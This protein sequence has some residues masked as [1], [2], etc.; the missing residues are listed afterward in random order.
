MAELVADPWGYSRTLSVL[1]SEGLTVSEFPWTPSRLVAAT[2]DVFT[3]RYLA[4]AAGFKFSLAIKRFDLSLLPD[5]L[6][7]LC[8]EG[9]VGR[10]PCGPGPLVPGALPRD[11]S[12]VSRHWLTAW[13]ATRPQLKVAG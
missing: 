9:L 11:A 7:G 2:T 6:K 10:W 13:S 12:G 1:E 5:P 8:P 4:V 3:E